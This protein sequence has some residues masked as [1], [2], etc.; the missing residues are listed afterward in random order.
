MTN[1]YHDHIISICILYDQP[2][3]R[4]NL[5]CV[6]PRIDEADICTKA[7]T[8]SIQ[9]ASPINNSFAERSATAPSMVDFYSIE[10]P[11]LIFV[12]PTTTFQCMA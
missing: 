2:F 6:C 1:I 12:A 10:T 8:L 11:D 9:I 7:Y 5:S 3:D 4:I